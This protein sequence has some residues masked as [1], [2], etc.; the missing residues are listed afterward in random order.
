MN[1]CGDRIAASRNKTA[2]DAEG[3][4]G[5]VKPPLRTSAHSAVKCSGFY[6]LLHRS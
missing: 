1:N 3:R 4:G 5:S 6:T 2:E